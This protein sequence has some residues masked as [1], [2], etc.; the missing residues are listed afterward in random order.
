VA[1][2]GNFGHDFFQGRGESHVQHVVG[3]VQNQGF[4]LVQIDGLA[5]QMVDQPARRSDQDVQARRQFAELGGIPHAAE[6]DGRGQVLS[7]GIRRD[8]VV[9]LG[10]QLPGGAQDERPDLP[11][12]GF[13]GMFGKVLNEGQGEGGGLSRTGLRQSHQILF[14]QQH[15]DAGGLNGGG[16]LVLQFL[17]LAE[18]GSRQAK[19]PEC[20]GYHID[21][22]ICECV[23]AAV[24]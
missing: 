1:L 7:L 12:P 17:Q 11:R 4:H 18:N 16:G 20:G 3:F 13:G 22:F 24:N 15:G 14:L 9:N 5:F 21:F 10:S 2:S 23:P 8:V 19:L 6:D